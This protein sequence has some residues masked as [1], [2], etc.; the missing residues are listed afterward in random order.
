MSNKSTQ[1]GFEGLVQDISSSQFSNKFYFD[2]KNIRI[3]ATDTQSTHSATNEKGNS[4]I[5][6]V[7]T[8]TIN[9]ITKI[10]SYASKTLSY[11]NDE[12]NYLTQSGTQLIIGYSNSRNY[13]ILFTTDNN[14]FDCIWKVDYE[15]YD[16]TLL[17]L[18]NLNFSI[19]AP[20]QSVNNFENEIIDKVYWVDGVNQMRFLNINHS[21]INGDLEELIDVSQNVIDMT[22]SF[23]LSSPQIVNT[24]PG[25]QHTAGMIQ[26]AY[27]L[28]R[29]NSSQTKVS[30]F[31]TLISLDRGILGGGAIN[32]QVGV[33]PVVRISNID[34]IYT[35]IRVYSIKYTS[36]NETPMIS[37]IED[38]EIPNN[39]IVDIFDDGTPI[40]TLSLEEFLFLGSNIIIPKHINS[41]DNRLFFANYK[42][43]NFEI[44]LDTRA[45]SFKSDRTS[46]VHRNIFYDSINDIVTSNL[47]DRRVITNTFTNNYNDKFDSINLDYDNY[48]F[49]EDGVTT[50]GEGKYF[51][52]QLTTTL[53]HNSNARYF[54]DE[55]IYRL[56]IHFYN[57][58]GEITVPYWMADFKAL[59]GNLEGKFNTLQVTLKPDFFVW[60]NT[61]SN[62][63]NKYNKPVGYRILIAERTL[64]DKTIISNGLLSTMMFNIKDT[65]EDQNV[66]IVRY[67]SNITPKLPNIL[68]RN[69]NTITTNGNTRP[70]Y[71]NTHFY[72]MARSRDVDTETK[73]AHWQDKDTSGRL[74]QFN[75]MLQ[76]YS[77]E[78]LFNFNS[79]LSGG[80]KLRIKGLMTN[81]FNSNWAKELNLTSF[82]FEDEAK[83]QNSFSTH[84]GPF[85][86]IN[87]NPYEVTNQGIISHPG[88]GD[89]YRMEKN[90]FYRGYGDVLLTNTNSFKNI[91][92]FFGNLNIVTGTDPLNV[93]I[94][95]I[96]TKGITVMLNA[97]YT[98]STI[99]Y[100]I[101][102]NG[103]FLT[104]LYNA[105]ISSDPNGNNI[106]A[107]LSGVIGNQTITFTNPFIATA[108][109]PFRI[110]EYYLIIESF[111]PITGIVNLTSELI[112]SGGN[113]KKEILAEQ[114]TS[115]N[116]TSIN[117]SL[118]TPVNSNNI[119]DIYGIPEATEKGQNYTTYNNDIQYRYSNSLQSV[120]TDGDS[121]WADDG[122]C[123]RKIVSV[124]TDGQRCITLVTDDGTQNP[125]QLNENR[126]LL[127]TIFN[128]LRISG[129]NY[130]LIGELIRTDR[131]IYL[132]GIY[133][134]NSWEDKLRTNYMEVGDYKNFTSN[135]NLIES[136]G[137]TFVNFFRFLRMV[138]K[139]A[140]SFDQCVKEYE[141]IVEFY[142]ETTVDLKNRNDLSLNEWD[143]KFSY[144]N[145]DYHKYNTVYSQ[146]PTLITR[147]AIDYNIKK[148]NKFDTNVI[149]SKLK[150]PGELID[151]WTDLLVNEV[152]TLDGKFGAINT[153]Q[154]FNDELYT[155]QDKAFAF[156]SIN[157]RVQVQGN[158]GLAI[159]LGSGQVLQEYKYISTDSGTINKWSVVSSP[160]GI[161]YFDVLNSSFNVFKGSIQGLSDIKGLHTY[162]IN[163]ISLN[164]LKIDNPLIKKGIS[165]GYDFINNDVFMT[166]LQDDNAYTI[167]YNEMKQ[168]F[169]SFYDYKPSIY[170]SKGD[171]FITTSPNL[172]ELWK[173][174]DGNYNEFYGEV[175]PS[176]IIFNVNP[177][178]TLDC[179]FDN[180]GYKSEVTLNDV[181]QVDETLTHIQAYN[182]YQDS[183]L[184]PL[185]LGRNGNIRR[186]FRDWNILIPREGR[187][188]IRAPY[189]KLKVQF[190]NE[191]NYKLILH[192]PNIFYTT[193]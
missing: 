62:F 24:L 20:I 18:R 56:G 155:L 189:I 129:D 50:G 88:G 94:D 29:L 172:N 161:Y 42:E 121:H 123:I 43:N 35:N 68:I 101:I 134:G 154:S 116:T 141:E 30:P 104:E 48:K 136:P 47:V 71:K 106:I 11:I 70:L 69:C 95:K 82:Q 110:F 76:I 3:V 145:N 73:L 92:D 90:L 32:E 7:P 75:S 63:T 122:T 100:N 91:I 146:L 26:Y 31:S 109:E 105:Q 170:I 58:Y 34:P 64:N 188:R 16:I 77:P 4:L 126:P 169:I 192:T 160:Q 60:L 166:F 87:G 74:Y 86:T 133:G 168:S 33:I 83:T 140:E 13:I 102:P 114:F 174:Y 28:Y 85:T 119:I 131:E 5:L 25:G 177:E 127:E 138:R 144:L 44:N 41:K 183:T 152:I 22:G 39:N 149:S 162:F 147:R 125:N 57:A 97:A 49:Q 193:A 180:I 115:G 128:G 38:R 171:N 130:G 167:S 15:T 98:S 65:L 23:N 21:I 10:I 175:Y 72:P 124:N 17:Y 163:N 53:T 9:Y 159:E 148:I 150:S 153:L 139:D 156:L 179:V 107:A 1:Q 184:I 173:Q 96:S 36:Y 132:G 40:E 142:T 117:N 187:N 67:H 190:N 118:Y 181:D 164:Q 186:K 84:F 157:P 191:S 143:D 158:D 27:N 78:T 108:N 8:P 103:L 137:D 19:N 151:N 165:S 14:G 111:N 54:K 52:Y 6:T 45:Y 176:Y 51:K 61:S 135:I 112:S 120:L 80:L 81:K 182:D 185:V 99:T 113:L 93:N 37:L 46:I 178:P 55:E 66:N 12:I 79:T 59:N 2:A 89:A